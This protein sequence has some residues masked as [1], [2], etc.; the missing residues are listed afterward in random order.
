VLSRSGTAAFAMP[1]AGLAYS[2]FLTDRN[3]Q[4][5]MFRLDPRVA[6]SSCGIGERRWTATTLPL[7]RGAHQTHPNSRKTWE[8]SR[9][10]EDLCI[11]VVEKQWVGRGAVSGLRLRVKLTARGEK[12]DELTED[13]HEAGFDDFLTLAH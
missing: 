6:R 11:A 2:N 4:S 12:D 9:W 5:A 7:D 8:T 13:R 10:F 3:P 1:S